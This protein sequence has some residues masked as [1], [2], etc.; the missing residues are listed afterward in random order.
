VRSVVSLESLDGLVV[1]AAGQ[2][3]LRNSEMAT[4]SA[5]STSATRQRSKTPR[6]VPMIVTEVGADWLRVLDRDRELRIAWLSDVTPDVGGKVS[7]E[8]TFPRGVAVPV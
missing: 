3:L 4:M 6:S 7:V 1:S 5:Q 8:C 2:L